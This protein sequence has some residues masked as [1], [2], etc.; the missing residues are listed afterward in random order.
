MN[1][2]ND[3]LNY[4]KNLIREEV[5]AEL[6]RKKRFLYEMGGPKPTVTFVQSET[7]GSL[8]IKNIGGYKL[9]NLTD[10]NMFEN[11]G[12]NFANKNVP[13]IEI[14]VV[15]SDQSIKLTLKDFMINDDFANKT[16][17]IKFNTKLEA[18]G[19]VNVIHPKNLKVKHDLSPAS[20][21]RYG[22]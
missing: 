18:T 11:G 9:L 10:F 8:F 16:I 14:T 5:Q 2:K 13:D 20:R 1:S 17:S 6:K 15:L 3:K 7:G 22:Y 21:S 19:I 4:I 12:F